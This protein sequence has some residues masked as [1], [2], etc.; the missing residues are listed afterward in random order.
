MKSRRRSPLPKFLY[1]WQKILHYY[2]ICIM[3]I[4]KYAKIPLIYRR[5]LLPYPT[6]Y[7]NFKICIIICLMQII[8]LHKYAKKYC[9]AAILKNPVWD[10]RRRGFFAKLAK[11][12]P[13]F[14][15]REINSL[16]ELGFGECIILHYAK[17]PDF[18]EKLF[19]CRSKIIFLPKQN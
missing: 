12:F 5:R 9:V 18:R 3:H 10:I 4:K 15:N 14:G 2:A 11:L 13:I 6:S 1:F 16:A 19:F 17:N 8:Y 7:A